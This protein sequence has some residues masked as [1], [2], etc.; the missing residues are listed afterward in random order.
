MPNLTVL[1][2]YIY[3]RLKIL[4]SFCHIIYPFVCNVKYFIYLCGLFKFG[5]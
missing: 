5:S 2:H 4:S 1:R 3:A